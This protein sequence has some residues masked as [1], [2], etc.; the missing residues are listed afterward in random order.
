MS[1]SDNAINVEFTSECGYDFGYYDMQIEYLKDIDFYGD[2]YGKGNKPQNLGEWYTI[3]DDTVITEEIQKEM[4]NYHM[5]EFLDYKHPI[6]EIPNHVTHIKIC[7]D[8]YDYPLDNLSCHILYLHIELNTYYEYP[9]NNLPLHLKA[10]YIDCILEHPITM[11]PLE[12]VALSLKDYTNHEN[13]IELPYNLITFYGNVENIN[14]I[15]NF[16]Q[17]LKLFC[18]STEENEQ[19]SPIIFADGLDSFYMFGDEITI[20]QIEA[21]PDSVTHMEIQ[22]TD[23]CNFIKFPKSLK[24]LFLETFSMI[25]FTTILPTLTNLEYIQMQLGCI[26]YIDM[27]NIPKSLKHIVFNI[28]AMDSGIFFKKKNMYN[29]VN[30]NPE[31]AKYKRTFNKLVSVNKK[32][33]IDEME[34]NDD[35]PDDVN[36]DDEYKNAQYK[37][38]IHG[39]IDNYCDDGHT[40]END[41]E[42]QRIIKKRIIRKYIHYTINKMIENGIQVECRP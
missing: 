28:D 6:P 30:T 7:G 19:L 29:L 2:I 15:V 20:E 33:T 9:I 17:C 21:L 3:E 41:T 23:E 40:Q 39:N 14:Q 5:I 18:I 35:T 36:S 42:E 13:I 32:R 38:K 26:T 24:M 31:F 16:S 34:N 11:F 12:L 4:E 22:I 37:Y 1:Q 27:D 25:N 8:S 10:L